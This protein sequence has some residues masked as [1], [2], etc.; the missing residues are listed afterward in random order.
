MKPFRELDRIL[1]GDVA[2]T[3]G[4]SPPTLPVS[5]GPLFAANVLLAAFYGVCMGVFGIAGRSEPEYRLLL[6]DAVKVPL[7]F[8]LTLLDTFPSLYVFN[9]LVG[10]RLR[11]GDLI[12]VTAA[13]M[14]ILLSVLAA[15][16]PIVAFFSVTT[17]S[18]P[19]VVLL[20]VT[21]FAV[22]GLFGVS[23]L[24]R[25]VET[26]TLRPAG[27]RTV[28]RRMTPREEKAAGQPDRTAP[29]LRGDRGTPAGD[30][31][32]GRAGGVPGLAGGV[33]PGRGADEL[34]AAAVHR[35][36][37]PGVRLGLAAGLVLLRRGGAVR[38]A[39]GRRVTPCRV[40][41]PSM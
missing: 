11:A 41:S 4:D 3:A 23:Y 9:A 14:G 12:R 19:F 29:L 40:T 33:R 2:P 6:A 28:Y 38:P 18:Y 13:A 32:P 37:D 35:V 15:F 1:R 24:V 7:L 21:V 27:T 20:N 31:G 5:L 8:A 25:T 39:P 17:T 34:G 26:M 22:A 30:A 16:G 10:S 36:A